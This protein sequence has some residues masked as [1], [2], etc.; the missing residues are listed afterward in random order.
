VKWNWSKAIPILLFLVPASCCVYNRDCWKILT[1]TTIFYGCSFYYFL[2]NNNNNNKLTATEYY[3]EGRNFPTIL[4]TNTIISQLQASNR[5]CSLLC[6]HF[7]KVSFHTNVLI[8]S[9]L[10]LQLLSHR[11]QTFRCHTPQLSSR[12]VVQCKRLTH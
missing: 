7:C 12:P 3:C 2:F 10:H 5:Q 6:L 8:N 1:L 9:F 11:N 4:N